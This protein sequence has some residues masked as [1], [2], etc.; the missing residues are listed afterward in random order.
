RLLAVQLRHRVLQMEDDAMLFVQRAHKV[1]HLSPQDALHRPLLRGNDMNLEIPSAQGSCDLETDEA[2][3]DDKRSLR[4]A[5]RGTDRAAVGERAK[6]MDTL[7]VCSRDLKP[8]GLC[9]RSKKQAVE[10][11]RISI[12]ELHAAPFRID[13][14]NRRVEAKVDAGFGVEIVR[15]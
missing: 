2:R 8:H 6:G 4:A 12:G 15:A 3:T 1:A 11:H 10:W 5:R 13:R 9:A 14:H 7:L